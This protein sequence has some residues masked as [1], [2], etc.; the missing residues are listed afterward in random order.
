M[1]TVFVSVEVTPGWETVLPIL[2]KS[3]RSDLIEDYAAVIVEQLILYL[4]FVLLLH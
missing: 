3:G 1:I 4:T 2:S